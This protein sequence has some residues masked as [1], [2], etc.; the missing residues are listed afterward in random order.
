MRSPHATP[1]QPARQWHVPST[2]RPCAEQPSGQPSP[3]C[4][5]SALAAHPSSH[6]HWPSGRQ[7]PWPEQP[8]G[9]ASASHVGGAQPASHAHVPLSQRPCA[10]HAGSHSRHSH[11]VPFQPALHA[12]SPVN[13]LHVPCAAQPGAHVIV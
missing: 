12:H 1:T 11:D 8:L 6:A 4:E 7:R 5:Q 10:P 13:E 2:Q 3:C 9:H